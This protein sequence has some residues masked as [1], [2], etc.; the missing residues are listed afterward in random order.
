MKAFISFVG[1][2]VVFSILFAALFL[3]AALN[4]IIGWLR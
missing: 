3:A 1:A 2:L 4:T